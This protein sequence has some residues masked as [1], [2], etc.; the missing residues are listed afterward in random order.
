MS[1]TVVVNIDDL[2]ELEK[3]PQINLIRYLRIRMAYIMMIIFKWTM[4]SK[5]FT[6][7]ILEVINSG[8]SYPKDDIEC[9]YAKKSN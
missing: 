4:P 5:K 6:P 9:G 1:D 7:E 3:K 2:S 8:R